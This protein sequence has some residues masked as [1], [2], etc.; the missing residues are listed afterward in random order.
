M[1]EEVSLD[2]IFVQIGGGGVNFLFITVAGMETRIGWWPTYL[3][4]GSA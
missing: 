4:M 2:S 1:A 3:V